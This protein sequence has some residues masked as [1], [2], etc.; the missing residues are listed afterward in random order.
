VAINA[1]GKQKQEADTLGELND[2]LLEQ[3]VALQKFLRAAAGVLD[4]RGLGWVYHRLVPFGPRYVAS[5]ATGEVTL[6]VSRQEIED[7]LRTD[8]KLNADY[9]VRIGDDSDRQLSITDLIDAI[10]RTSAQAQVL[11]TRLRPGESLL[12]AAAE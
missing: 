12:A 9:E 6:T 10:E 11:F 2:Q 5:L 4:S 7:L 1:T 8:G 3:T